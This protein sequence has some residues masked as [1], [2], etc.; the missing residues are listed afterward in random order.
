M[1]NLSK[2]NVAFY[3]YSTSNRNTEIVGAII[4]RLL[5]I[6]ILHQTAT[7][8]S[9]IFVILTLL[10]I[11][12]LHQTATPGLA[13]YQFQSCFLSIFYIKPQLFVVFDFFT[14]GC[15]LSIFYIKPQPTNISC[16]MSIVAFYLYSTSNRNFYRRY[17]L[18]CRVAFYLYSTSN[19]NLIFSLSH[20]DMLL[21][22][23]ILHQTATEK[24]ED[25]DSWMLLF[26]YILHQTATIKITLNKLIR[27]L[28][29]Y[30]LHQTATE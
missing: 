19:R 11:Y 23:Y 30:I 18:C 10:F 28:F 7:L 5:F 21:F 29:I 27:L 13:L 3:L 20:F 8:Y 12:I 6:Y 26:I 16:R 14:S 25:L 17:I 24:P 2:I 1:V 22:I 15:F 9:S 4:N